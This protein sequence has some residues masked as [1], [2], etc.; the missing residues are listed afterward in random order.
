MTVVALGA[1]M[2]QI[3]RRILQC[4]SR[5][6]ETVTL[7]LN[8]S[9]Q[10]RPLQAQV[11]AKHKRSRSPKNPTLKSRLYCQISL[12]FSRFVTLAFCFNRMTFLF[13]FRLGIKDAWLPRSWTDAI[14]L[15]TFWPRCCWLWAGANA[16]GRRHRFVSRLSRVVMMNR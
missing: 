16:L 13:L 3:L 7:R 2:W 6:R 8:R 5:R 15:S 10:I 4:W 9:M 12:N 1:L 14:Q 11:L